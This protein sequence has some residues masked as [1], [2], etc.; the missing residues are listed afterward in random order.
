MFYLSLRSSRA[1][2]R[3]RDGLDFQRLPLTEVVLGV[4]EN[5]S[6]STPLLVALT[7]IARG[8]GAVV[9]QSEEAASV[10]GEDDLLLGPFNNGS[11][12]GGIRLLE[13]LARLCR[14]VLVNAMPKN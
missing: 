7:S 13:L 9:E 11:E 3:A 14:I 12:L 8:D 2:H 5:L 6:R 10:L 4:I 1:S